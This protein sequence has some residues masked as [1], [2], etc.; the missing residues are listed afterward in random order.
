MISKLIKLISIYSLILF[1][2]N[3][4]SSESLAQVDF[5]EKNVSSYF[6]GS[7]S[8]NSNNDSEAVKY[9]NLSKK[10]KETHKNYVQNYIISLVLNGKVDRSISELKLLQNQKFSNFFEFYLLLILEDIKKNNFQ[11]AFSKLDNLE[12]FEKKGTYEFIIFRTLKRYLEL[13]KNKKYD[14]KEIA[15]LGKIEKITSAFQKCYLNDPDTSNSFIKIVNS[16]E[17]DF[18]RYLFFYINHKI[19]KGKFKTAAEQVLKVNFLNS[20]LITA[21]TKQWVEEKNYKNFNDIF[22]CTNHNHLIGEFLYLIA[23][24][25]S[26]EGYYK[27]SNFYLNLSFYMNQKFNF[28]RTLLLDNYLDLD[29]IDEAKKIINRFKKKNQSYYWYALKKKTNILIEKQGD[30]AAFKFITSEYSKINKPSIKLKYDLANFAKNAE[31]YEVSIKYY[32]EI[33]NEIDSQS[34]LYAKVLYRRGGSFERL[35]NYIKADDDLLNS[36]TINPDDPYVMNYLGYSW[37]ERNYQIDKAFSLLEKANKK[38]KDDPYITDSIG[39]AYYLT[40]DYVKAEIF[41]RKAVLLM[42]NDPIV[43]DHY[44]DILWRLGRKIE[45]RY[46]WKSVLKLEETELEMKKKIDQKLLLGLSNV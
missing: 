46:F 38:K 28:N 22:S 2:Q 4:Y 36:L 3:I 26:S 24:L 34:N 1:F 13:F 27:E 11:K 32:S 19:S 12:F 9:Y 10:L 45:A 39:W 29:K 21:Q 16:G 43:N 18:S 17:N 31:M 42:P 20:N 15:E 8:L 14:S 6:S 33:L 5:T 41:I 40:G 25:Y 30:K 35:G 37:L 7:I 23:N 44:G